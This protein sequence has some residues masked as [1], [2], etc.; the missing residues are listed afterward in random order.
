LHLWFGVAGSLLRDASDARK[1]QKI[2]REQI[3]SKLVEI[4]YERSNT[5][6]RRGTFRVRGDTIEVYPTYEDN[7]YRIE[8]W[9]MRSRA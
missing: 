1:G 3:T 9:A 4:L 5:D 6:F 2:T 7:A 8:M